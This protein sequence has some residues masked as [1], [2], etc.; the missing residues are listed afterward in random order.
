M[1]MPSPAEETIPPE[2]RVY[3]LE[4]RVQASAAA[5]LFQDLEVKITERKRLAE[6]IQ[7]INRGGG[8][9]PLEMERSSYER[10]VKTMTNL[11]GPILGDVQGFFS[12]LGVIAS[13]LWPSQRSLRRETSE[14]V[15]LRLGRGAKIRRILGVHEDSILKTRTGGDEDVRGGLLHFDEMID[16][17]AQAHGND[18][19]VPLEIGSSALGTAVTRST[20][21]R[22]LD[23]DS[24]DLWVNGRK[25]NL[26]KLQEE[27][28]QTVGRIH[29][30]FDRLGLLDKKGRGCLPFRYVVVC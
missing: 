4:L 10:D 13:I 19:T 30:G 22:W 14:V 29:L 2:L 5:Y 11:V 15:D 17:F 28:Q 23:E 20:A 1:T 8:P 25:G 12:A 9:P 27:L 6:G 26:R 7:R 21:V 16:E 24:L 3:M 18:T